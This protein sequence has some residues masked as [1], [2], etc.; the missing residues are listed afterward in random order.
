MKAMTKESQGIQRRHLLTA[1]T[2]SAILPC[3]VE[4]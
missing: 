1:I 3:V 2:A 4:S